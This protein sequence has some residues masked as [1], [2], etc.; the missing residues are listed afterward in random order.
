LWCTGEYDT[1]EVETWA[2]FRQRV[3]RA[4][5]GLR[6]T[7]AQSSHTVVVTSGGPIAAAVGYALDLP[8]EKAIEFVWLSRNCSFAQFLFS[9]DRFSLHAFN[10]I[11]H[12][13][14]LALVT[15][16]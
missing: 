11:P 16:R 14:D 4:I 7:A 15:Y 1:P 2:Q 8:N 5:D 9:G 3:G 12:L 13:D 10:A 6:A